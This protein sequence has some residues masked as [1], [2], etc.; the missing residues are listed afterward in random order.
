MFADLLQEKLSGIVA[1]ALEQVAALEAHYCLLVKWNRVLNLTRIDRVEEAV[2][3]HYCESLFLGRVFEASP[4][5][6][7]DIGSGAGF[8]GFPIA[9]LRPDCSVTLMESH[10]R[11]AAFLKEATRNVRN[12]RV[13]PK[14]AEDADELFDWAVS[15]AVSYED[16]VRSLQRLAPKVAL[17]SGVEPPPGSLG[18]TWEAPVQVPWGNAR[19]VRVGRFHEETAQR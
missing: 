18:Y 11:K 1:L 10:Q 6:I 17:L 8:P 4:Q 13:L 7:V 14:R 3:R 12:V 2:E 19:F 15:R 9:V 5:R 16:L